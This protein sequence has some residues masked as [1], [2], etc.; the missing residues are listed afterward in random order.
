MTQMTDA[1]NV[2][3]VVIMP[4]TALVL[5]VV[6]EDAQGPGQDLD[7]G[8]GLV[9]GGA[10]IPVAAAGAGTGIGADPE[11]SRQGDPGLVQGT[12]AVTVVVLQETMIRQRVMKRI[13]GTSDSFQLRNKLLVYINFGSKSLRRHYLVACKK[14]FKISLTCTG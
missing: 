5:G 8:P 11:V 14:F 7:P 10:A 2:G 13:K 1:T 4:T 3:N 12:E 6:A 9:I